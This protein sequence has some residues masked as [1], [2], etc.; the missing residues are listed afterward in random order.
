MF[1]IVQTI[2]EVIGLDAN[3]SVSTFGYFIDVETCMKKISELQFEK[4]QSE[5]N[6]N[7]FKEIC[8]ELY[9]FSCQKISGKSSKEIGDIVDSPEL[10][11]NLDLIRDIDIHYEEQ[12]SK[13]DFS[14]IPFDP[15]LNNII[16]FDWRKVYIYG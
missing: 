11:A 3:E 8:A 10:F 9:E 13:E 14:E 15:K 2:Y 4:H 5:Y 16:K 6:Y 12:I 1:K 7:L